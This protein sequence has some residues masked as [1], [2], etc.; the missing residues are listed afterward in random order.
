MRSIAFIAFQYE[1]CCYFSCRTISNDAVI[2]VILIDG[3]CS[4]C[5]HISIANSTINAGLI[6]NEWTLVR[7]KEI[8]TKVFRRKSVFITYAYFIF[9][10]C[11]AATVLTYAFDA[12]SYILFAV[13]VATFIR[14]LGGFV[15]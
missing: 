8:K 1:N 15:V 4:R 14:T 3:Y 11:S 6:H 5:N 7:C 13:G 10:T 2:G 9:I 12:Y